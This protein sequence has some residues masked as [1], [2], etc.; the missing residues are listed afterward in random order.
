MWRLMRVL[1]GA[2]MLGL[3]LSGCDGG[4][5][6]G[7]AA[8]GTAA[9]RFA[10]APGTESGQAGDLVIAGFNGTLTLTDVRI[11]VDDF[12][13]KRE[14]DIA[15]CSA[16]GRTDLCATIE[17]GPTI[18]DLPLAAGVTALGSDLVPAGEYEEIEFD[19]VGAED[20][21]PTLLAQAR[22]LPGYADWPARASIAARGTFADAQSG[23]VRPFTVYFD[24]GAAVELEFRITIA[25]AG[26]GTVTIHVDPANWLPFQGG[27]IDLSAFD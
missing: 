24:L 17:I 10:A 12:E 7:P 1:P 6:T 21:A 26:M 9:V 27:V 3:G 15:E 2:L 20:V 22:A 13:L 16:T 19:V 14:N 25:G 8:E 23:E 4:G 11:V 18:I 5:A